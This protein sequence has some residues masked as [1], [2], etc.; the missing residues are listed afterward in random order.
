LVGRLV[1]LVV[2]IAIFLGIA[3]VMSYLNLI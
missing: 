3:W 2:V 1:V